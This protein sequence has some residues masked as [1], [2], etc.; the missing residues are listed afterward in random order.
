MLMMLYS[1]NRGKKNTVNYKNVKS[2]VVVILMKNS[3]QAFKNYDSPRYIHR[4]KTAISDTGMEFPL[5]R[6]IAF[7]QLDKAL[8]VIKSKIG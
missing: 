6:Q 4:I 8:E 2:A 5:L 3:P 1:A 7:V